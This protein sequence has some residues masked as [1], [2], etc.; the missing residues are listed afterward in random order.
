M[1]ALKNGDVGIVAFFGSFASALAASFVVLPFLT[2]VCGITIYPLWLYALE[3]NDIWSKF[4]RIGLVI[5]A[6]LAALPLN[7][8]VF[9]YGS[10]V[11]ISL[12]LIGFCL[13]LFV[14]WPK[15]IEDDHTPE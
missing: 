1:R 11:A 14:P 13:F 7:L 4:N 12:K 10:L 15:A 5:S 2:V 3:N 8:F 6:W 9:H